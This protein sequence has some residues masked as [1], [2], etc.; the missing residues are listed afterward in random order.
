MLRCK[1]AARTVASAGYD[2]QYA[3]LE[4]EFA[5]DG[6]VMQYLGVPE[7]LWYRFRRETWPDDFFHSNI[8]GCYTERRIVQDVK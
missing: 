8:K 3:V 7:D 6:Q 2:A 4:V 1:F 5:Q